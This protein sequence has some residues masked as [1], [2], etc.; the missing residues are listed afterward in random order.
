MIETPIR[1]DAF[2]RTGAFLFL[3]LILEPYCQ[4]SSLLKSVNVSPN[5]GCPN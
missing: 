4:N 2:A 1:R 5:E 3:D